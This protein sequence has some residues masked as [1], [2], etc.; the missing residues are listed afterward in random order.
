MYPLTPKQLRFAIAIKEGMKDLDP[1]KHLPFPNFMDGTLGLLVMDNEERVQFSHLTIKDYL[2]KHR[3]KYFPNGHALLVRTCLTYLSFSAFSNEI[4]RTRFLKDGD[5][6]PFFNYAGFQ[7]GNHA[8]KS[9]GDTKTYDMTLTWL[10]SEHFTQV[11]DARRAGPW[12]PDCRLC[13]AH[14]S[15]LHETCFFGLRSIA[16]KLLESENVNAPDSNQMTPLHYAVERNHFAVIEALLQCPSLDVN[17][18]NRQGETALHNASQFGHIEIVQILLQ[19]PSI[20]INLQTIDGQTALH[21]ATSSGHT[22]I[23]HLL[24]QDPAIDV[25][26]LDIM[27]QTAIMIAEHYDYVDA[28]HL[29]LAHN[30]I[31]VASPPSLFTQLCVLSSPCPI[32]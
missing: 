13:S 16:M 27:G 10:L 1:K 11:Q 32:D 9:N 18:Q 24:L 21:A 23:I 30:H 31:K 14:H 25:N 12:D 7:W 2:T 20:M 19:Q 22:N 17:V 5:L 26:C 28:K 3:R 29:L 15:P 6:F 8:R 4:G